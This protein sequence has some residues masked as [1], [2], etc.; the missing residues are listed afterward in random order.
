[1]ICLD[2]AEGEGYGTSGGGSVGVGLRVSGLAYTE[3]WSAMTVDVGGGEKPT[4]K[5]CDNE[6]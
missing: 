4:G 3:V 6:F 1:M 2:V 5:G